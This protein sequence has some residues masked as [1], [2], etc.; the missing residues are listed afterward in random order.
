MLLHTEIRDTTH[1]NVDN[2]LNFWTDRESVYPRLSRLG[3]DL[4]AAAASQAYVERLFSLCS[5]LTARKRN[6]T[7]LSVTLYRRMFLKLNRNILQC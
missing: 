5:E 3:H 2:A 7:R 6:R 1:L 4:V